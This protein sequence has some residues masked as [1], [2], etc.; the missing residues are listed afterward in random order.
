MKFT[1]RYPLTPQTVLV[2]DTVLL[3]NNL[4]IEIPN[5]CLPDAS[6]EAFVA[7]LEYAEEILECDHAVVCFSKDRV[8]RCKLKSYWMKRVGCQS[9]N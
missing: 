7:L 6:K 2:W 8:D 5:G 3:K 1:F 4:Y 9:I